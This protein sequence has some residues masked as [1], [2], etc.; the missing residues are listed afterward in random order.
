MMK[1]II[2]VSYSSSS[3]VIPVFFSIV[4]NQS[5]VAVDTDESAGVEHI[6]TASTGTVTPAGY[7][8][9]FIYFLCVFVSMLLILTFANA[10]SIVAPG[11]Q[12]VNVC[13]KLTGIK[14]PSP[15]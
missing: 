7:E 3:N 8:Y 13:F 14:R 15:K 1:S 5:G 9:L 6:T 2:P 4:A 11:L 10:S 12:P